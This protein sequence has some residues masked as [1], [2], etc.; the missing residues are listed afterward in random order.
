VL[1]EADPQVQAAMGMFD[2]AAKLANIVE[3]PGES[4]RAL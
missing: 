3:L 4:R 1:A 2:E